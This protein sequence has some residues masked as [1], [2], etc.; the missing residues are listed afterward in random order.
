MRD[1]RAFL[2][3]GTVVAVAMMVMNVVT[4]GFNLLAARW[5][6]PAEFGALTA[7]LSIILMANVVSLGLQSA[8]ARRLAVAPG[9]RAEIVHTAA[10][11]ALAVAVSVGLLV[12][13]STVVLTP[14]LRLDSWLPVVLCGAMMVPLTLMGAQA[15][16]AQGTEQW[17]RLSYV[18]VGNG[19]GRLLGGSVAMM[20]EPTATGAMAGLAVGGWLPVIV[21]IGLLRADSHG[22]SPSRLPLV[23]ETVLSAATLLAYFVFSNVDALLA[24]SLFD[25]HVA[26]LYASGLIMTKSTLFLPQFVSVIV[27]PILARDAGHRSRVTAS[28]VVLGLGLLAVAGVAVLPRLALALVGGEQYAE[29]QDSLW[30]FALSGTFLAVVYVLVFDALAKRLRTMALLL[31]LGV[32]TVAA[33][34]VI[35]D[36]GVT[37]LVLTMAS[38]A[39]AIAVAALLMPIRRPGPSGSVA[40]IVPGAT[41][42]DR[43]VE[44]D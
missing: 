10:R 24:R 31:W 2:T 5:L 32:G 19:V 36:V 27:F 8:I 7:L 12:A 18:Y 26:G 22:H 30:M 4:Y 28:G 3:S 40:R 38:V 33:V 35:G 41:D 29:V 25:A 14:L 6:I 21:G 1:R 39:F 20:I 44:R 17:H 13:L 23:R 42:T 15:G 11:V 16:A 37:G 34:A 9:R 43:D